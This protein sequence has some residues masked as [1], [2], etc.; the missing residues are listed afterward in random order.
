MN[1]SSENHRRF[2]EILSQEGKIKRNH[3]L[4]KKFAQKLLDLEI[5]Q[6]QREGRSDYIVVIRPE[7]LQNYVLKDSLEGYPNYLHLD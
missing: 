5:V 1:E 7:N 6:I 3:A 4:S 2:L